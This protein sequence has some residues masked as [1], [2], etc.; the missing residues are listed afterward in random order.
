MSYLGVLLDQVKRRDIEVFRD[1]IELME[2]D[3]KQLLEDSG[4]QNIDMVIEERREEIVTRLAGGEKEYIDFKLSK[5]EKPE[6]VKDR[7]DGEDLLTKFIQTL[8]G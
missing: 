5:L 4:L 7:P 2:K 3:K 6:V 8:K 1:K